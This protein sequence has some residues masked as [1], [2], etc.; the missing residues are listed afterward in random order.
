MISEADLDVPEALAR[1]AKSV[2]PR[3]FFDHPR[4]NV[5]RFFVAG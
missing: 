1:A 5:G 2:E 4:I 3:R